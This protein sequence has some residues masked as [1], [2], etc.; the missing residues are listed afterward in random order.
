MA[1]TSKKIYE[2]VTDAIMNSGLEDSITLNGTTHTVI[3]TDDTELR[4]FYGIE[5]DTNA[6]ALM[7]KSDL[8]SSLSRGTVI[9]YNNKNY[10]VKS[11]VQDFFSTYVV[12]LV[13]GEPSVP[14][15]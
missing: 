11:K 9:V 2:Q 10:E 8:F 5:L 12:G 1:K 6:L 14:E 4:N 3:V 7:V 13:E 15:D